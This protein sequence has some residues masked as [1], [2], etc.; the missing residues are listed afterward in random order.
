MYNINCSTVS[1]LNVSKTDSWFD[2]VMLLMLEN[3]KLK[4][5][6]NVATPEY[7]SPYINKY[8]RFFLKMFLGNSINMKNKTLN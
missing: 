6:L 7:F 2:C 8:L 4:K 3:N 5:K 1:K